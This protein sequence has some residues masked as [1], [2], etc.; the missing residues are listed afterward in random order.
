MDG[1][2]ERSPMVSQRNGLLDC[3]FAVCLVRDKGLRANTFNESFCFLFVGVFR[4][5][6]KIGF[7][8]LKL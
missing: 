2:I 7:D 3:C 6:V 4:D 5:E 1:V 8:N